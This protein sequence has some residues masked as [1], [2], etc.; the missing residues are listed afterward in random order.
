MRKEKYDKFE[1]V[2]NDLT[3][4]EGYIE[5][6]KLIFEDE[7]VI[8]SKKFTTLLLNRFEIYKNS[9]DKKSRKELFDF[10]NNLDGDD[11][12]VLFFMIENK[13]CHLF[14]EEFKEEDNLDREKICKLNKECFWFLFSV[15][16]KK[17]I[18]KPK[19]TIENRGEYFSILTTYTDQQKEAH[20]MCIDDFNLDSSSYT[21]KSI[22]CLDQFLHKL[23]NTKD[24]LKKKKDL[25]RVLRRT[26]KIMQINKLAHRKSEYN[27]FM[28]KAQEVPKQF[29]KYVIYKFL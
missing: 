28:G 16:C 14:D 12:T 18:R 22:Y 3:S 24:P 8:D 17:C 26:D 23:K 6:I 20:E 19:A 5:L 27:I 7:K 2:V 13:I 15:A 4:G 10:L 21:T 25:K 29:G 11:I 9:L 1:Y